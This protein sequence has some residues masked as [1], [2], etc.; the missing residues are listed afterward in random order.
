MGGAAVAF[1]AKWKTNIAY[2]KD[3]DGSKTKTL[4]YFYP[5][6][7]W[8]GFCT[9]ATGDN[10]ACDATMTEAK[11][12]Q[13]SRGAFHTGATEIKKYKFWSLINTGA[14]SLTHT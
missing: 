9:A 14:H 1:N 11:Y 2:V 5:D 13:F 6:D 8:G 12:G 7:K 4:S 10:S 3:T